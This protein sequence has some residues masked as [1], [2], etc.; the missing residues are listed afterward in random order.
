MKSGFV[1]ILGK[2][3]VGKSTLLNKILGEKVSIVSP[4]PQTTRNKIL[5]ILNEPE[6]QIIFIDTPGKHNIKNKLD[7]YMDSEIEQAKQD[8]DIV[9]LVIDG[10][11]RINESDYEFVESFE[12]SKQKVIVVINKIDDTTFEKLYPQLVRFNNMKFVLDIIPISAK[13]GK[14]VDELIKVIKS[15]LTS[16][17]KYFDDDIFTDKSIR[18]MVS[19][20]IREKALLY[21]Q[22]EIPHGIAVDIVEFKEDSKKVIIDADIIC[23]REAHK[24]IIL[25]RN[26]EMIKKVIIDADII[27][28]REAHKP[29]ILGRNGEMIK[30][31]GTASRIDIENLV[32]LKVYLS[33]FVKV[34]DNWRNNFNQMNNLGYTEE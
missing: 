25:G 11:K 32:G 15:N 30:K 4:K 20:I 5:G 33:L 16:D 9:L 26:G 13:N 17:I 31:I 29:I 23:E 34:R 14:N 1:T 24:P 2:P 21:L 19:E 27:C 12:K 18:F 3:N 8:V 7:K 6:Y 22:D 28:E 10:S